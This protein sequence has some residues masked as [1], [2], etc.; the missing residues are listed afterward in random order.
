[1][2]TNE[3]ENKQNNFIIICKQCK[4]DNIVIKIKETETNAVID[5]LCLSCNNIERIY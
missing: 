5:L 3:Y 4:G 2:K 1:M